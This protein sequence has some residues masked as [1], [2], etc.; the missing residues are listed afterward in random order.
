METADVPLPGKFFSPKT[1]VIQFMLVF[2]A[3]YLD[4]MLHS[5]ALILKD[6]ELA[7]KLWCH[8]C[9]ELV[10]GEYLLIGFF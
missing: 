3:A 8:R 1:P 10:Y 6:V 4:G 5:V 2:Y 7:F 9:L